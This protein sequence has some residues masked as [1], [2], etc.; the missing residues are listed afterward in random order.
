MGQ[1]QSSWRERLDA[2]FLHRD[3]G[4]FTAM[5]GLR[6]WAL[7]MIFNV[8][9]FGFYEARHY[10]LAEGSLAHRLVSMIN[11]GHPGVDLFFVLSGFLIYTTIQRKNPTFWRFLG[12]RWWRLFPVILVVNIPLVAVLAKDVPTAIDNLLLLGLFPGTEY[13]NVV[14]WALTYQLYFYLLAGFWLVVLARWPLSQ[15]WGFYW[16]LALA[17]YSQHFTGLFGPTAVPRFMSLIWGLGL[18]KLFHTPDLWRRLAPRLAWAW[19][20]A[21][22]LFYAARWYWT[23]QAAAI[24]HTPWKWAAYFSTVDLCFLLI[25]ASL[26]SGLSRLQGLLNLRPMR[27][28]GTVSYSAFLIHGVWGITLAELV[29]RPLGPGLGVLGLHYLLSWLITLATAA[30]LFH[31][32]EKPYYRVPQVGGVPPAGR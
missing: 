31:F 9:F 22:A 3:G 20:P 16:L 12:N 19:L 17:L 8:H 14:E 30:L 32:L 27:M 21:L 10:F 29:V 23:Y 6:G 25:V 24:V 1:G 15:G 5:D 26:L 18:A 28:L 4:R 7:V 11:A 2:F 13:I